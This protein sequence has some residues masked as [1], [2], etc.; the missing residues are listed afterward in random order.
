MKKINLP[1][2]TRYEVINQSENEVAEYYSILTDYGSLIKYSDICLPKKSKFFSEFDN[3]VQVKKTE[4]VNTNFDE[5]LSF[6]KSIAK[7]NKSKKEFL[8]EMLK[9]KK[10]KFEEG[11]WDS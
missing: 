5:I 1:E 2:G 10:I 8:I 3:Y 11:L 4:L 6:L 7:G 9:Q